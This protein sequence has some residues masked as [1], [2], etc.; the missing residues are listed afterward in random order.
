MAGGLNEAVEARCVRCRSAKIERAGGGFLNI[1]YWYLIVLVS[2][3][4]V[5]DIV[6][7]RHQG[8]GFRACPRFPRAVLPA[9]GMIPTWSTS[10]AAQPHSAH[11]KICT[12]VLTE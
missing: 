9:T 10:V 6:S 12:T 2:E 3:H 7:R 4:F 8:L 1:Y 5:F 11:R